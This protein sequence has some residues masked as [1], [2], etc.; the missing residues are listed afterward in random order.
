MQAVR[1]LVRIDEFDG[2]FAVEAVGERQ[3]DD[4]PVDPVVGVEFGDDCGN[5]VLGSRLRKVPVEGQHPGRLGRPVLVPDVHPRCRV[6]ADE[7]R[8]KADGATP[9]RQGGDPFG[10][11]SA[12]DLRDLFA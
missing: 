7:D 12:Y 1:V 2:S 10:D 6:V 4:H 11:L 8:G 5:L 3:L 9:V